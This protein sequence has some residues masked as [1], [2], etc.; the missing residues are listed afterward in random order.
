MRRGALGLCAWL[1]ACAQA[2]EPPTGSAP[3]DPAPVAA[4]TSAAA[5]TATASAGGAAIASPTLP[6]K[7]TAD[8]A[9]TRAADATETLVLSAIGDCTLGSEPEVYRAPGSFV[10][11]L[12]AQGGDSR[13]PFAGVRDVLAKDDLTLANLEGTLTTATG[14]KQGGLAFKGPPEFVAILREGSVEAVSVANNHAYDYGFRGA[15][16]TLA[17]LDGAGIG[18]YGNG[19]AYETTKKGLR[20][21]SLGYTGGDPS[22]RGKMVADVAQ[23]KRPDNFLVV[24]FHWGGEGMPAPTP[25]QIELGRAAVDAGADLVLGHHPHVLQGIEERRGVP[26]VYS[27]GNFVFGGHSNPEDKDSVIY[28]EVL[29]LRGGRVA[30]RSHRLLPVRISSVTTR[31]DYPPR[32]PAAPPRARARGRGARS[33]PDRTRPLTEGGAGAAPASTPP[34][35]AVAAPLLPAEPGPAP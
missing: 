31:N 26:I 16:E 1:A 3:S 33:P 8:A 20:I 4:I 24:S 12:E 35:V 17:V 29:S 30:S 32:R 27:L 19:R 25:V 21:V 7:P 15:E 5:V 18:A 11:E 9:G 6:A 22:V 13:Y 2:S 28:Q 10:H 23:H 34:E 14:R